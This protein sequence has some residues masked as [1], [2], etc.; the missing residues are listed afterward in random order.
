MKKIIQLIILIQCIVFL[1]GCNKR[2]E[3]EELQEKMELQEMCIT[4]YSERNSLDLNFSVKEKYETTEET[5]MEIIRLYLWK[6]RMEREIAT[7]FTTFIYQNDQKTREYV[8]TENLDWDDLEDGFDDEEEKCEEILFSSFIDSIIKIL[9]ASNDEIYEKYDVI[10]DAILNDGFNHIVRIE[11]YR[12]EEKYQDMFNECT[13]E[14]LREM[15][16][17]L[18]PEEMIKGALENIFNSEDEKTIGTSIAFLKE[19]NEYDTYAADIEQ[20]MK[21]LNETEK[22][23]G[24]QGGPDLSLPDENDNDE[25]DDYEVKPS[26][27][28]PEKPK[29]EKPYD[30]YDVYEYSH[31]DD[32][33][34]DWYDDFF[35][36]EDAEDYWNEA[37]EKWEE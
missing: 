26:K 1:T 34:Y 5:Y 8:E 22:V 3:A 37:W 6:N 35:D 17:T 21:E 2:S 28:E 24:F 27:K 16:Y 4:D 31:P 23:H 20:V 25:N 36:Y 10:E 18:Y 19:I 11:A 9:E 13:T 33:Y 32:F 15:Y 30:P 12:A 29:K 14:L 7:T